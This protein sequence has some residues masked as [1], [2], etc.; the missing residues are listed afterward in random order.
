[1][2]FGNEPSIHTHTHTHTRHAHTHTR[3]THSDPS[4][5]PQST[6]PQTQ[7]HLPSTKIAEGCLACV[8]IRHPQILGPLLICSR[9]ASDTC[10]YVCM[11]IHCVCV[12]VCVCARARAYIYHTCIHTTIHYYTHTHTHTHTHLK[13]APFSVLPSAGMWCHHRCLACVR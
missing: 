10:M 3:H 8:A 6:H 7:A 9:H 11:Y 1:L 2:S 13:L 5:L 4:P 12:C